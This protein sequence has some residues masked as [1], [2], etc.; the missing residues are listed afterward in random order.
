MW[1]FPNSA[2]VIKLPKGLLCCRTKK[3]LLKRRVGREPQN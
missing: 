3:I 2:T 1:H